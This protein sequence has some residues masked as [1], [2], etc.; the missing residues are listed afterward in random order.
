MP[1]IAAELTQH[2][3]V[4]QDSLNFFAGP[5]QYCEAHGFAVSQKRTGFHAVKTGSYSLNL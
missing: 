2:R 3:S 1:T 5:Q 4:P